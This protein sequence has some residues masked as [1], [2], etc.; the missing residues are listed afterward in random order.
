MKVV[1][2]EKSC[3]AYEFGLSDDCERAAGPLFLEK[4]EQLT[5]F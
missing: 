4:P 1:H 2:V 5:E 3:L